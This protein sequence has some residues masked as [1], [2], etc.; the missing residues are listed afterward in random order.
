MRTYTSIETEFLQAFGKSSSFSWCDFRPSSNGNL[1][2]ASLAILPLAS[3]EETRDKAWNEFRRIW[4]WLQ[5]W[6][7][8]IDEGDVIQVVV[9][10]SR[11]GKP[12]GQ[13][14]KGQLK[15]IDFSKLPQ[16]FTM[17]FFTKCGDSFQELF[18]WST[19]AK[20]LNPI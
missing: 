8:H 10:F 14:F 18:N 6:A 16:N 12:S 20:T 11:E 9:G 5:N 4:L 2:N 7:N 17:Q 13:I 19:Y 15:V 1:I 3:A